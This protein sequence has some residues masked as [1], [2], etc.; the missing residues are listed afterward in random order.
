MKYPCVHTICRKMIFLIVGGVML[1]GVGCKK[2]TTASNSSNL[3][4]LPP[5]THEGKNTFGC[6]VNGE[7][8][9]AYAPFTVGGAVSME[10]SY[11]SSTGRFYL[12]GTR[13]SN[14]DNIFENVVINTVDIFSIGDYEMYVPHEQV[15]GFSEYN[16][17]YD[18]GNYY[19]KLDSPERISITYFSINEGVI[20]GTFEMDL[21]N[22]SCPGDTIKIREGRFDWR[23]TVY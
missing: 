8:W 20:S 5:L 11:T 23:M 13:K 21:V 2:E 18:C 7:V 4:V 17:N 15:V 16:G 19:K 12:K 14:E 9:V 6:K 10:G 1:C 22:P 3:N